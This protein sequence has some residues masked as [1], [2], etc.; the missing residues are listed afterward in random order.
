[1][2]E[3]HSQKV[4]LGDLKDYEHNPRRL[5][6]QAMEK[7]CVSLTEDGYHQRIVVSHDLTIIGGHQ[8]KKALLKAGFSKDSEIEVLRSSRPLTA[9][10]FDRINIRDNLPY[11]SF[12]TD[13]LAN[14]FD[15]QT[16]SNFGM[17]DDLLKSLGIPSPLDMME[18][19][20]LPAIPPEPRSKLGDVYLLGTHR[21]MCGDSTNPTDVG[22][23]LN[24]NIPVLM[25]TDPPYGVNYDPEWREKMDKATG[26][27]SKGKVLN[28]DRADWTDA[29]KLFPGD[30]AYVWHPSP[31]THLFAQHLEACGFTLITLIIWTK[32]HFVL[33]RGDYH[34]Q[35]ELLWYA[36]RPRKKQKKTPKPNYTPTH[37]PLWYS[38][39]KGKKHHWQG[40]RDQTTVW[41][42]AN[43]NSFGN[44]N[45][46]EKFGH[47]TQKPL[48]CMLRPILNNSVKGEGVY[49][50]FCGSGTTLIA[51]EK[52][53]R[54]C[55]AM[56]LSPAYVD[57][58]IARWEKETGQKAALL[59]NATI[60]RTP[61]TR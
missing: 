2:L 28:D 10:E 14:R 12:D 6:K 19:Q 41:D 11:G 7:L 9:E 16:L 37:E 45:I 54:I 50:P 56:E 25:V 58:T 60:N 4:K 30:V 18:E 35:H 22:K 61:N 52:S 53:G 20:P 48:E 38:V 59:Q 29:Y 15:P 34:N 32:Q 17:P 51:C 44:P 27:F 8:R 13:I 49:D 21:L 57:M 39:K 36:S 40:K 47:G 42:I 33:S 3:W 23:L 5:S 1:M 31:T 43:N 55:Y 46:E 24:N 26:R